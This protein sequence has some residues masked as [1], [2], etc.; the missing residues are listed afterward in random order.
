MT[1]RK[2]TDAERHAKV[3]A[4]TAELHQA[5]AELTGS[6]AW[7]RMLR[8]AAAFPTYSTTASCWPAKPAPAAWS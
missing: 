7:G 6:D 4:A 2:L 3:E 5:V 1:R 8:V